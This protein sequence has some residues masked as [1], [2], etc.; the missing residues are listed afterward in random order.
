MGP[1]GREGSRALC[2]WFGD[3]VGVGVNG[4]VALLALLS[5]SEWRWQKSS[6]MLHQILNLSAFSS[7]HQ[8]SMGKRVGGG[9]TGA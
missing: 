9:N 1:S 6:L 5:S 8:D 3:V 7:K 2:C 4:A